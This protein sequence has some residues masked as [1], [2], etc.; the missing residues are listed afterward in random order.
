LGHILLEAPEGAGL[1]GRRSGEPPPPLRGPP[2]PTGEERALCSLDVMRGYETG[3]AAASSY[4][5]SDT[6][7]MWKPASTWTTSPVVERPRSETS[8]RAAPATPSME[9][10]SFRA[11]M[12]RPCASMPRPPEMPASEMAQVGRAACR[13]GEGHSETA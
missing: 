9:V 1:Q 3:R 5:A 7:M 2:R 8:H 6:P 10:S 13:E 11:D 4:S 12:A